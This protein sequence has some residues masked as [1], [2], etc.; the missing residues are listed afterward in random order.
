[1]EGKESTAAEIETVLKKKVAVKWTAPESLEK[2]VYSFSS[3][4]WSFGILLWEMWSYG[5]VPYRKVLL[6]ENYSSNQSL[7]LRRK[8]LGTN[9]PRRSLRIARF[10]RSCLY[11]PC[12]RAR[13]SAEKFALVARPFRPADD[14]NCR[15]DIQALPVALSFIQA[16]V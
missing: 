12:S 16:A 2:R 11:S 4:M 15:E 9:S 7:D 3:E 1:M 13:T 6:V 5:R 14:R 8:R 10:H